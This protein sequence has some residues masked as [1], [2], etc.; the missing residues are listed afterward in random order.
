MEDPPLLKPGSQ[1]LFF[2][3]CLKHSIFLITTRQ[4]PGS[5]QGPPRTTWHH[6]I[7]W[8]ITWYSFK[9]KTPCEL[10]VQ[11]MFNSAIYT[12]TYLVNLLLILMCRCRPDQNGIVT[13]SCLCCTRAPFH[14]ISSKMEGSLIQFPLKPRCLR[15]RAVWQLVHNPPLI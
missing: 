3:N 13:G 4:P 11:A 12:Q 10:H 5:I 14:H 7:S 8:G 2:P 9:A 6:R 15:D 1:I